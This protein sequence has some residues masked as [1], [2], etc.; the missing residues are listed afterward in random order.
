MLVL[1]RKLEQSITIGA[2]IEIKVVSIIGRRVKL[3]I[4]APTDMPIHRLEKLES[5]R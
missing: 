3:G 4:T 1:E 2:D 5:E